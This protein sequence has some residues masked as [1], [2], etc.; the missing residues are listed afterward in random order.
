[1]RK[2][3]IV[4]GVLALVA[5]MLGGALRISNARS[6]QLFGTLVHRVDTDRPWVALTFDDGPTPQAT[7]TILAILA[8][9]Q[10]PATFFFTG[11]ELAANPE[12]ARRYVAAG[13]ELGNHSWS[14]TRQPQLFAS[15]DASAQP[16]LHP[17]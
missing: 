13:H 14:R 12:L 4:F 2:L 16:L 1:M 10:V 9:E 17:Q 5:V 8:R 7:D 3:G 11:S 15:P 6:F